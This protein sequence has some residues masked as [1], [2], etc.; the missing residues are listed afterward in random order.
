MKKCAKNGSRLFCRCENGVALKVEVSKMRQISLILTLLFMAGPARADVEIILTNLGG[1]VIQIGYDATGETQ[2]VRSFALDIVAT[3][4]NIIDINDY[5]VGDNNSG[6]GI[7]PGSFAGNITVNS[8]TGQVDNWVGSPNP[9]TPVA[10]AGYPDVLGEIPGPAITIEL[11]SLY[12]NNAP[13]Q[14]G[15]LCTVTVD[16][17]VSNL[18]V[19]GNARRNNVL[20]ENGDEAVLAAACFF[21]PCFPSSAEY[22]AQ[23]A[24]WVALAKPNCWC[25]V[26]FWTSGNQCYGDAAGDTHSRGYIVYTTDLL[27]IANSW[28]AK[29]GDDNL[30]PCA[31]FAHK[32]HGRGYV[33][34]TDDLIILST[35]WKKKSFY[36]DPE[37]GLRGDNVCCLT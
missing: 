4:G 28:K 26:D 10:P 21:P 30:D 5:S 6:Y 25:G 20:L 23:Y 35:N 3:D 8:T 18:C 22:A 36:L 9:Y 1:G 13:G 2:L 29:I 11:G 15:V 31:D 33:V 17:S 37:N 32:S 24:Q 27:R 19:T 16:E 12:E 7:F 34:Y 14:T